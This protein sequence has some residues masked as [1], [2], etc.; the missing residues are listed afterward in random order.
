M[1]R[2]LWA[3]VLIAFRPLL[4]E[5]LPTPPTFVPGRLI[6]KFKDNEILRKASLNAGLSFSLTSAEPLF[7][8]A[9]RGG[10]SVDPRSFFLVTFSPD[11]D[12]LTAAAEFSA[13]PDVEYAQPDYLHHL[14]ELPND[15]MFSRQT[16]WRQI[17]AVSAWDVTHGDSTVVIAI[18]DTGVDYLHEDLKKNIWRNRGEIE[19]GK[20]NDG[21]GYV[22]DLY[23]WDFVHA[24]GNAA[25]DEDGMTEDND[26]S[27]RHGHGT[28]VAGLAAAVTNNGIGVA[29]AGWNCRI[30]PLRVGYKTKDG[31][32]SVVSSAVLKAV[33][34][35]TLNGAAIISESFGGLTNDY[36]Q[37][38]MLRWAFE[39][40][41]VV[42]KSA[43]NDNSSVG[44]SPD[45]ENWVLTAAAVDGNDR[46]ASFSNYGDWVKIS[47]PGV[48]LSTYL[49]N[50]YESLGGTSM[51][52]PIVAGTTA[53]V[54]AV[55]PDWSAAKV[56]MH[57]VDTADKI[58]AV[59]PRYAGKLGRVGRVNAYRAVSA[60]FASKP[61]LRIR[62][63]SIEDLVF[64]NGDQR[65]NAGETTDLLLRITNVW[66]R[67]QNVELT[68]TTTD[69][70]VTVIN[71][72]L[73]FREIP[74]IESL[75]NFV[76]TKDPY[77]TFRVDENA[78]PHN[79]PF[80]LTA[81]SG[82][83][84][85]TIDFTVAVEAKLL[86]V[87]DDGGADLVETVYR[88]ILDSLGM[89]Y[90]VW[91]RA[92]QGRASAR[93]RNYDLL[94]WICGRALPTLNN[95]DRED[96]LSYLRANKTLWIS[97]QD[98]GWDLAA[99]QSD[100][101]V[102]NRGYYNQYRLYGFDS[103]SFYETHLRA[104]FVEDKTSYRLLQGRSDSPLSRDLQLVLTSPTGD[105]NDFAPDVIEP[106]G[107]KVLFSYPDGRAAAVHYQQRNTLVNFA[108]G[109]LEAIAEADKRFELARRI[110]NEL[111]GISLTVEPLQN[112]EIPH[113]ELFLGARVTSAKKLAGVFLYWR[114]ASEPAYRKK[115]MTALSDTV[116]FADIPR[117]SGGVLEY[118]V[119]AVA[120]DG[121][122]SPIRLQRVTVGASPPTVTAE[123]VRLSSLGI[124]PYLSM[125]AEDA[126]G[127][128]V[129]SARVHFWTTNVPPD[130]M[131]LEQKDDRTFGTVVSGRFDYGDTLYYRFSIRDLSYLN[132]RGESPI[133][134]MVLGFEGFESGLDDWETTPDGWGLETVRQRSGRFAAHESPGAGVNYPPNA[135]LRLTL[136]RGLDLSRLSQATLS[137]WMFYGFSDDDYGLVE[138]SND[139][140]R[141][142]HPLGLPI[143]GAAPKYYKAEFDLSDFTGGD[144]R[145]VRIRFRVISNETG[146]GPG[147]FI[148][149][150]EIIP[151]RTG[152]AANAEALPAALHLFEAHPN[153]FNSAA[154]ITF[155]LPAEG[156]VLLQVFDALGRQVAVLEEGR[157]SAGHHV[158]TWNGLDAQGMTL[159]SGLYF[160][161]LKSDGGVRVVKMMLLR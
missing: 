55:H 9:Q 76:D 69:P 132:V 100:D 157:R 33:E 122:Y 154:R 105:D 111:T 42:V 6:V 89:A 142:W 40:G 94:F 25:S 59:N 92:V 131:L 19:D 135:D 36:A 83:F 120:E 117:P 54:R 98:I 62:R 28:H 10:S 82:D 123:A 61:D 81:V 31:G 30:M 73:F 65:V 43:G 57:V 121:F 106:N 44:Y 60:P 145:D 77:F 102:R 58:D 103:K 17:D 101:D 52:A 95:E 110:L 113:Q 12:P 13:R 109:G 114:E 148:D 79:I 139:S 127:V 150:L 27:D 128:D 149:D 147:W 146:A 26:P 4:A 108:F 38:D 68:L 21:N 90:D 1:K 137:L 152:V 48:A 11:V 2:L 125:N 41:V 45:T 87:D 47:A 35:A 107:G 96:L 160:C 158:V 70:T 51:A 39:S 20:D 130:S 88:P 141:T 93:L 75:P 116:Y 23:G 16:F 84:V 74:G 115:E 63:I 18:L 66:N 91:D 85:Q 22:D 24:S 86:L 155:E 119:Q 133:Y 29:G 161:R 3:M 97:G 80:R 118:G 136:K 144:N 46:K 138:A 34:Y 140:G 7:P 99:P 15:P 72:R 8:S 129:S 126:S 5:A 124:S 151:I 153:P 104:R 159:P 156:N 32:G 53:L 71:D 14:C 143:R 49:N 64:G 50:R 56:M 37:R 78:F 134:K 67:A 112:M